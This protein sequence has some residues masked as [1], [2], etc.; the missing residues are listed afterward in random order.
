[1]SGD[2]GTLESLHGINRHLITKLQ[3]AGIQSISDLA[4]T[5]ASEFLEEYY[6]NYDENSPGIDTETISQLIIKAKQKLIDDGHLHKEFSNAEDM[7]EVRKRI[8]RFT[9]GSQDFDPVT[10]AYR[11]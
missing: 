10:L 7:L 6:S 3:G 9:S 1:M 11:Q 2:G 4:T 8:V 5:T